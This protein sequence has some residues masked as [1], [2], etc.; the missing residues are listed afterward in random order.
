M[1]ILLTLVYRMFCLIDF[2]V[3]EAREHAAERRRKRRGNKKRGGNSALDHPNSEEEPGEMMEE[4]NGDAAGNGA[5]EG[6]GEVREDD[7]ISEAM[8]LS[9]KAAAVREALLALTL[10]HLER[11]WCSDPRWKVRGS[12]ISAV[13]TYTLVEH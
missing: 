4:D 5:E 2:T 8:V 10:D 12:L 7:E 1:S 11:Y 9:S 3:L 6:I 13:I